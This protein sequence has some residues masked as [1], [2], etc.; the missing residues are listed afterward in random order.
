MFD[1]YALDVELTRRV[2]KD[3]GLGLRLGMAL[4]ADSDISSDDPH[5]AERG[6][7]AVTRALEIASD[8][9]APAVSGITYAAFNSYAA[10]PRMTSASGSPK[11]SASSAIGLANWASAWASNR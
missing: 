1:P 6:R 4:G 8:L 7:A 11:A 5:T 9:G 2:V 10:P 3:A